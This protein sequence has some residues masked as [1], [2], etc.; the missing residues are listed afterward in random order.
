MKVDE[1][2]PTTVLVIVKVLYRPEAWSL[3]YSKEHALKVFKLVVLKN[4]SRSKGRRQQQ[5]G[6]SCKVMSFMNCIPHQVSFD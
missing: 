5:N 3:T 1:N 6:E 2:I 4:T